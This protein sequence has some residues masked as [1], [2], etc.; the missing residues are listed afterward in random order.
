MQEREIFSTLYAVP[1]VIVRLD[2]RAFHSLTRDLDFKKPFDEKFSSAM[3]RVC[4]KILSDS[5]L[6]P[7]FAY[8]FSDEISLYFEN[9]PFNGRIEKINSVCAS[10]AASALL[11]ELG[12]NKPLAFDSRVIMIHKDQIREYLSWRQ[13]EAWRNHMNAYCQSALIS[14]GRSGTETARIM[15]GMKSGD[16]HEM[17]FKRGINLA[18]TPTWQRRG[19]II[20]KEKV[21]RKGFNPIT[22]TEVT[23]VRTVITADKNPPLFSDTE[24]AD[25]YIRKLLSHGEE[26]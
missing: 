12:L 13:S 23:A 1:P 20:H 25:E 16:M 18:E 10:Y 24:T 6:E 7:E 15:K 9:L 3:C 4:R 5:G 8:T 11:L 14:E 2:G 19:T 21:L 22:N 26:I 17:M